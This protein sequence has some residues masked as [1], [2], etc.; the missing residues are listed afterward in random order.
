MC[1]S[2]ASVPVRGGRGG[3][4]GRRRNKTNKESNATHSQ[5]RQGMN[6]RGHKATTT[7]HNTQH[8]T[9]ACAD[10]ERAALQK[11]SANSPQVD[12]VSV[13]RDA[14]RQPATGWRGNAPA[15]PQSRA[16]RLARGSSPLL[17]LSYNSEHSFAR[18]EGAEGGHR[19]TPRR[20]RAPRPLN[21]RCVNRPLPRI[22]THTHTHAQQARA[23]WAPVQMGCSATLESRSK[24]IC[25]YL[26]TA[27]GMYGLVVKR[28][29]F[30]RSP[31]KASFT[32]PSWL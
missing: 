18:G 21:F 26:S 17:S 3:W 29:M 22:R 25:A 7:T 1:G 14:S 27:A 11:T 15:G 28:V 2:L 12:S 30:M 8:T 24:N 13:H 19:G 5:Q 20:D 9:V 31:L 10:Y 4:A 32:Y 6:N 16:Q 23:A